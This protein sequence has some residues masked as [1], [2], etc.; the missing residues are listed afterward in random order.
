V[1][2]PATL[3]SVALDRAFDMAAA[4]PFT[5]AYAVLLLELG[6]PEL[7]GAFVSV[8]T[9]TAALLVGIAIGA[10]RLRQRS[11]IVTAIARSTGIDR[12]RFVQGQMNVLAA[13]E[14]DAA[15]LAAQRSRIVGALVFGLAS[16]VVVLAEYTLLLS[17]FGLPAYPL[18]VVAAIFATGAAHSLPVPAAVGVLEGAQMFV[19]GTLGHPPEVG[20][21][22][23]LAVRLRE[24]VW[25]LPGIAF[26]TVDGVRRVL[27]E[28]ELAGDAVRQEAGGRVPAP[29]VTR[30]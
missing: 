26:L 19:F 29:P 30:G 2:V 9:A 7:R 21:A 18:A 22:V 17:A 12:L 10:R 20:L 4:V 6:V 3:A 11:G 23:G 25:I 5:C 28:R 16:N 8:L 27:A 13:A 24:L 14:E 1:S 15:R